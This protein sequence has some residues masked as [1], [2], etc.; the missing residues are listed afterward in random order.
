VHRY[1]P[2][3]ADPLDI[4]LDLQISEAE[5]RTVLERACSTAGNKEVEETIRL[6]CIPNLKSIDTMQVV[7]EGL[8]LY[9]IGNHGFWFPAFSDLTKFKNSTLTKAPPLAPQNP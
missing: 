6:M 2:D 4:P 3:Q 9:P 1:A 8:L 5:Q 7:P